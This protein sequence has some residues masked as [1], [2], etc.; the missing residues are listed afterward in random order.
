MHFM[1]ANTL[2]LGGYWDYVP[3]ID[4]QLRPLRDEETHSF[5]FFL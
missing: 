5:F 1:T 3:L 2:A 4:A